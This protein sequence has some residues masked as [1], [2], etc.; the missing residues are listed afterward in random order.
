[1]GLKLTKNGT[2]ST[3]NSSGGDEEG[4]EAET[5]GTHIVRALYAFSG[6]NDDEVSV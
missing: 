6:T 4:E 2:T 5:N 3:G 1:M